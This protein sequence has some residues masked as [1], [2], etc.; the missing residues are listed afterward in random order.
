LFGLWHVLPTVQS[1][2]TNAAV[3]PVRANRG[4]SI[5]AVAGVVAATAAA[6]VG[7]SVLGRRAR[8]VLAPVLVHA[9]LN[10]ATYAAGRLIAL[11]R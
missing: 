1:L 3:G 2:D 9:T 11:A 5:G 6:G 7:F 4:R 10:G 8:S